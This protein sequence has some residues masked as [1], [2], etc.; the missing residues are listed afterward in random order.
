MVSSA[1]FQFD[2]EGLK[3]CLPHITC[4]NSV[5]ICDNANRR[6]M[7][8]EDVVHESL[9]NCL[10][11]IRMGQSNEMSNFCQSVNH[12]H[13]YLFANPSTKSMEMCCQAISGLSNGSRRP[14]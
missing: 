11:R 3:L 7:E 10:D 4:E 13:N 9:G 1:E 8:L 6:A 14:G 2:I 5:S 12:Y